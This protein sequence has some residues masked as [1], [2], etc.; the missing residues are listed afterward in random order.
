MKKNGFCNE[1]IVSPNGYSFGCCCCWAK[2]K[3]NEGAVG[4]EVM[5]FWWYRADIMRVSVVHHHHSP[6]PQRCNFISH[7]FSFSVSTPYNISPS[8]C[9]V[10]ITYAKKLFK[11]V[12]RRRCCCCCCVFQHFLLLL[13][14]IYIL[15]GCVQYDCEF[16]SRLEAPKHIDSQH[17][18]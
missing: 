13:R 7:F 10:V 2:N 17:Y 1:W 8:H 6:L 3:M 16:L 12:F 5:P 4:V 9:I 18:M 14:T 11:N 15:V